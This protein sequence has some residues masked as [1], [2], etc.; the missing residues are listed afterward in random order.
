[1][2]NHFHG[3]GFPATHPT[4]LGL[5]PQIPGLR[6]PSHT[7]PVRSSAPH[8]QACDVG[9][10]GRALRVSTPT[11]SAEGLLPRGIIDACF[12]LRLLA[13]L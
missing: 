13:L 9:Q 4:N 3:Q 1:M 11:S 2:K 8:P 12:S 5:V 10:E 6:G 7:H